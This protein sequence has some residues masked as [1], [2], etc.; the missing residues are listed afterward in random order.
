MILLWFHHHR[1]AGGADHQHAAAGADRFIVDVDADDGI[2]A[3]IPSLLAHFV[4]RNVFGLA[5]L[6]FIRRRSASHD[7]T[8]RREEIPKDLRAET[9][10]V[11]SKAAALLLTL[12]S[13]FTP[14]GS[15]ERRENAVGGHFQHPARK[16]N[17]THPAGRG[18]DAGVDI[19]EWSALRLCICLAWSARCGTYYF[20]SE[21][22]CRPH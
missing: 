17:D 7:I 11:P 16:L 21:P 3:Q 13:R 10:L 12:V 19:H 14:H 18:S 22:V 5:Q 20:T 9:R 8:N 2:G 6:G 15:W 1:R 4:K